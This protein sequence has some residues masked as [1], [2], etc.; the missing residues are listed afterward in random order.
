MELKEILF[1]SCDM[2]SSRYRDA[3]FHGIASAHDALVVHEALYSIIRQAG[4]EEEY[5]DWQQRRP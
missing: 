1:A 5:E 2:E 4:L 3:L